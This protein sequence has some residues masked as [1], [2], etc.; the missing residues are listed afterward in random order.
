MFG[1]C[2]YD[3]KSSLIHL[4]MI[5]TM[6]NV[7]I[8]FLETPRE[9]CGWDFTFIFFYFLKLSMDSIKKLGVRAKFIF[10][11]VYF[12]NMSM[13]SIRKL[14]GRVETFFYQ[15]DHFT[16]TYIRRVHRP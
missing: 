7:S 1:K 16:Q 14:E 11:F 12:L 8:E 4:F 5:K 10:L 2:S 3:Q 15:K 6:T 9:G 13:D